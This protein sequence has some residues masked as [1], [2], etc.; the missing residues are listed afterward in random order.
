LKRRNNMT[1]LNVRLSS[2]SKRTFWHPG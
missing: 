2:F 1:S